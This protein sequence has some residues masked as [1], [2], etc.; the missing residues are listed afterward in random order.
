M[1]GKTP[2]Q[3]MRIKPGSRIAVINDKAEVFGR[4]GVE[5]AVIAE[6]PADADVVIL[7]VT[8]QDEVDSGLDRLAGAL[9]TT[10]AFWIVYPK[11]SKAA[12]LDVSRD[13]IWPAA[14]SRGMRPVGMVA[15]DD[16]WSGFRLK[17]AE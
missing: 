11:G 10:T 15:V 8:S 5:D 14:E 7:F 12:G 9:S 17:P 2:A 13:T 3:K 1:D 6:R 4:L 16:T